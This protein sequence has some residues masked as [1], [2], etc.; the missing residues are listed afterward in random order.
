[1]LFD[2]DFTI[3]NDP[4]VVQE[5][6]ALPYREN[7]RVGSASFR[8]IAPIVLLAVSSKLMNQRYTLDKASLD[9]NTDKQS[10]CFD[11]A[12]FAF[13]FIPL[14]ILVYLFICIDEVS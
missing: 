1:M 3:Q 12:F 2:G 10:I 4:S 8:H 7:I 11:F 5:G 6:C 9:R 13:D 14:Y